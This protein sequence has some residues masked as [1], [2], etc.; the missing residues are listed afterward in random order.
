MEKERAV[1][2]ALEAWIEAGRRLR[3]AD[4]ETFAKML[5]LARGYVSL[6]DREL[7]TA[8]VFQSRLAQIYAGTSKA[9]A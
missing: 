1:V 9:S 2:D 4:P 8:E 7:E 6:S 3:D 5:A